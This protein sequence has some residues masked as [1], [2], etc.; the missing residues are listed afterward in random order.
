MK[1]GNLLF[2]NAYR[3]LLVPQDYVQT[4]FYSNITDKASLNAK[5]NELFTDLIRSLYRE[6][7]PSLKFQVLEEDQNILVMKMGLKKHTVIGTPDLLE[8]E[9]DDWHSV[10]LMF[11][12]S[13]QMFLIQHKTKVSPET[14]SLA[15]KILELVKP[16]LKK[17]SLNIQI[18]P[19]LK[20]KSFLGYH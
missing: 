13:K 1:K 18:N 2:F 17:F 20:K 5:K 16:R 14:S 6:T 8:Q 19:I 12:F 15:N 10:Y 7:F 4:D 11:N 9:M 3:Y